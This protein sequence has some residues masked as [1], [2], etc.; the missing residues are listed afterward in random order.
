M[1]KILHVLIYIMIMRH[2]TRSVLNKLILSRSRGSRDG[3][4]KPM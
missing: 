1:Y 2:Y 4:E 3:T